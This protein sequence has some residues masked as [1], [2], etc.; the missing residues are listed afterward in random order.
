MSE[1]ERLDFIGIPTRD[2]ERSR[3]FYRDVLGLRPDEHADW[4][5]WAGETCF[6]IWEPEAMGRP[7]VAQQGNPLPLRATDVA[8]VRADLEAKGVV[9]GGETMDTGVCHMAFFED[10]D[11]NQLMLHRRYAPYA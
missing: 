9:F 4:E 8:A 2:K 11:G 10:P 5:Q 3:T 1:I 6:A 7:F